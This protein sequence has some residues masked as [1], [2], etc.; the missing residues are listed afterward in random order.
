MQDIVKKIA[1]VDYQLGNL[2]SVEQAFKH[3]GVEAVVTNDK[4]IIANADALVLPGVGAFADAMENM[5]KLDLV[6][7]VK[8]FVATGKAFMGVC[9]GLQILFTESE[10]FGSSKGLGIVDGQIR[11]FSNNL[12]DNSNAKVP[13]IAWNRLLEQQIAWKD[14]PLKELPEGGFQYFV[15]S[16]YAVPEDQNVI[17]STTRYEGFE[18]CS[19]IIK[20]NIFACQF[21]P[22]KSGEQGLSIYKNWIQKI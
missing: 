5:K 13:Q 9:L 16:Y 6:A 8:D 4:D 21:H 1:I 15:H 2:Y 14:T 3:L 11:K 19:S 12:P 7:P 17:L 10:E 22:E 20:K 18:Y